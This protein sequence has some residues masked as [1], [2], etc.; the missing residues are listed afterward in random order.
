MFWVKAERFIEETFYQPSYRSTWNYHQFKLTKTFN[1]W[2]R[3]QWTA[4]ET[5]V[6]CVA[7]SHSVM[8]HS[9]WPHGLQP[10]RP[11]CP[12]G[13]SRQEYWSASPCRSPGDFPNPGI[14]S[15]SLTLQ[16]DSIL[17]EPAGKPKRQLWHHTKGT[18]HEGN[19]ATQRQVLLQQ[20]DQSES[21]SAHRNHIWWREKGRKQGALEE[22]LGM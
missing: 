10:I 21:L 18:C 20:Q 12:W 22:L 17:S 15:R 6:C 1:V 3:R 13:F 9:L 7:L 11:L 16:V 2:K 8:S 5:T 19:G 4:S 14:E